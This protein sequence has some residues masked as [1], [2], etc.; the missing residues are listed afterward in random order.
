ATATRKTAVSFTSMGHLRSRRVPLGEREEGRLVEDRYAQTLRVLQLRPGLRAG[1]DV[2]GLPR[3]GRGHPTPEPGDPCLRLV[4]GHPVE[5]A[6]ED[7]RLTREGLRAGRSRGLLE[8]D[9][10]LPKAFEGLLVGGLMEEAP[11][12]LGDARADAVDLGDLLDGRA[13]HAIGR[14]EVL[15]EQPGRALPDEPDPESVQ[16]PSK[17]AAA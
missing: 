13:R 12:R 2:G 8:H 10:N 3:D 6:G 16:D 17:P 14:A 15:R 1:D 4:A 9:A 5:G 11:P 7:E